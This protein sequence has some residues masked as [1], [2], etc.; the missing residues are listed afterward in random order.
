MLLVP[1]DL[2]VD[3]GGLGTI[4]RLASG[5][6]VTFEGRAENSPLLPVSVANR[7]F[8]RGSEIIGGILKLVKKA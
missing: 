8:M 1:P 6:G 5:F 7:L 2:P 4:N 3:P